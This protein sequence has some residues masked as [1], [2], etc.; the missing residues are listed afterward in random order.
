[1][2]RKTIPY[3]RFIGLDTVAQAENMSERY[4]VAL[5]NAYVDFRGQIVKMGGKV[6]LSPIGKT[7]AVEHFG[8]DDA[9]FAVEAGGGTRI[10]AYSRAGLNFPNAFTGSPIIDFTQ[11]VNGIFFSVTG[12]NPLVYNGAA[13]A[14]SAVT[15]QGGA[16]ATIFK[17]L[18][19]ADVPGH[20]TEFYVSKL[21]V[22]DFVVAGIGAND[23]AIFNIA[24]ELTAKDKIK[25]LGVVE[26]D[27]LAV[28]CQNEVLMYK[29][30]ADIANWEI[31]RDF[32]I[33]FGVFGRK[34]IKPVGTDLFFCSRVGLHSLRRAISG[35]TLETITLS[36]A[37]HGLFEDLVE[38]VPSGK[39][40]AS[41]WNAN[42]GQYSIFFPTSDPLVTAKLSYT[43]EPGIG[44]GGHRSWS[45]SNDSTIIDGSFFAS[46]ELLASIDP[47]VGLAET[48]DDWD[49]VTQPVDMQVLTPILWQG[50][51]DRIKQ[52]HKFLLRVAGTAQLTIKFYNELGTLLQTDTVQPNPPTVFDPSVPAVAPHRPIIL[53]CRHRARG[54]QIEFICE[55]NGSLKILDFALEVSY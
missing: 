7:V 27:K 22:N 20:E 5:K 21:D 36:S 41:V 47:A 29:A 1:M 31:V 55:G 2:A 39:E 3:E 42:I 13:F 6:S 53:G 32:R 12:Q 4:L 37:V 14:I 43:Y 34:T 15:P 30:D 45:Y 51:P 11:F 16:N 54:L 40:P 44:K 23:A 26:G 49:E 35:I 52:Y 9:A 25:G 46:Q 38:N 33:P 18:C 19:I 17:R 8:M 28:F 24:N 10:D 48:E 50:A